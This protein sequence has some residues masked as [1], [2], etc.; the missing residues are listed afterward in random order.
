[1]KQ[2][3][4]IYFLK[5]LIA[6][7]LLIFGC[8]QQSIEDSCHYEG[9]EYKLVIRFDDGDANNIMFSPFE[10]NKVFVAFWNSEN[11]MIEFDLITKDTQLLKPNHWKK[12]YS[13][14]NPIYQDNND[15]LVWIGGPNRKLLK[16]DQKIEKAQYLPIKYVTRIVP[17]K[18]K[19]YFVAF[20][21]LFVKQRDS[22]EIKKVNSIPLEIIQSS[23]LLD[24][25]TLILDSKITYDLEAD[26][27]EEGIQLY[28]KKHQGEFYSFMAKNGIGI[29]QENEKLLYATPEEVK[30]LQ[31]ENRLG[32]GT[33]EINY[34]YIYARRNN[35]I[36][37]FDVQT[38][39]LNSFEYQ[40]PKVNNYSPNFRYDDNIIWIYRPGQ[41]YFINTLTKE[42]YNLPIQ[43]DEHF[44]SMIYDECHIY[45]LYEKR[46]E[47][48]EKAEFIKK[49]PIFS[50][51]D[52]LA[53]FQEF[54][55][56]IDSIEIR[57]E[58]NERNVVQKLKLIKKRY[59]NS[60]H[61][62]IKKQIEYLNIDAFQNVKYETIADFQDCYKNENLPKEQRIRC[63]QTLINIEVSKSNFVEVLS[64]EEDF[65][66]L[67]EPT[68]L[69]NMSYFQSNIDS[70][71][72]YVTYV[73]SISK[74]K[75]SVDTLDYYKAMALN[76]VCNTSF[77]CHEG[78]GGCDYSLVIN[79]L[80]K[81][82]NKHPYSLL[83]DNSEF[84][85]IEYEYMYEEDSES[86]ELIK[87][88]ETF[89]NKFPTSDMLIEADFR[90]LS[91]LFYSTSEKSKVGLVE[92]LELFLNSYS[93]ENKE[94]QIRYWINELKN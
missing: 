49:C 30:E 92:K 69:E 61:P 5:A 31:L 34:P 17:Y 9:D 60:M 44:E 59:T 10:R 40:L 19:T 74:V 28:H 88:F 16:Y 62:E 64:H 14:R 27:W 89:K 45:L 24:E 58:Q 66:I 77:F 87:D 23:Q 84:L 85:L 26:L 67:F 21:G 56:Y 1:M 57:K 37:R 2:R 42:S 82:S 51:A 8:K 6:V 36:D 46:L 33:I 54:N 15:S 75:S 11:S 12:I 32:S 52:Y 13:N 38:E 81:F 83:I 48:I 71:R 80:N 35:M 76:K 73:D 29:F 25:R 78:C 47:V 94:T 65:K 22:E 43:E 41:L 91:Q 53:E 20:K 4:S 72:N 79:A 3:I 68:E 70:L 90:I 63:F 7:I 55:S 18:S 39:E 93:D 50:I 86:Q